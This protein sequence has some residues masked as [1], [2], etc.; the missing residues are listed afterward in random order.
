LFHCGLEKDILILKTKEL[1]KLILKTNELV[2]LTLKTKDLTAG[3]G[4]AGFLGDNFWLHA[5]RVSSNEKA[6][7]VAAPSGKSFF[8]SF[9]LADYGNS[10]AFLSC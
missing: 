5:I 6:Q 8:Y 9:S 7:L 10:S 4:S 1:D 2:N 3:S